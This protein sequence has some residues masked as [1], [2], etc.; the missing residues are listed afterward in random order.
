MSTSL[1]LINPA[2]DFPSYFGAEV[3]G[4]R[5]YR[6]ATMAADLALP[7]LAAL[8]PADFDIKLC[9][10]HVAPIDFDLEVDFVGIT[11][12]ITQVGRMAAIA[13]EFQRRGRVV[14]IGGPCA[15]LSPQRLRP[16]CDIL[17]RGEI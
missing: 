1:Y 4:A 9:D 13:R 17:V 7:T 2:S 12:K 14:L 16:Y 10:E 5:G 15:S 3:F 6:P 8:A 11:G